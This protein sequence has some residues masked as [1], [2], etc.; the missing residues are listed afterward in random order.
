M[1]E[2]DDPARSRCRSLVAKGTMQPMK[3]QEATDRILAQVYEHVEA[4]RAKPS[5]PAEQFAAAGLMRCCA[6]LKGI[7][8]LDEASM[9]ALAGILARQHW[10]TWAV[11]LYVLLGGE[12]ALQVIAGDDIYWKRRLSKKL[13]LERDDCSGKRSGTRGQLA[14]RCARHRPRR[15]RAPLPACVPRL[16]ASRPCSSAGWSARCSRPAG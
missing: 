12:E 14:W 9:P 10:E 11:S 5:R 2:V 8:V 3:A 4:F 16:R 13:R 1:H 7:L 15:S 6:L